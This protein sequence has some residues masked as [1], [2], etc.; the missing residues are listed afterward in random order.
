MDG[1]TENLESQ[2]EGDAQPEAPDSA[3]E[4]PVSTDHGRKTCY[5]LFID[6][7]GFSTRT[8]DEKEFVVDK[9]RKTVQA[10]N[11]YKTYQPQG[12]LISKDTGDGMLLAFLEDPLAPIECAVDVA[13][14]LRDDPRFAMRLGINS[15]LATVRENIQGQND[16]TGGAV[17]HAARVMDCGDSGHILLSGS[18]A[19]DAHQTEN[20]RPYVVKLGDA[21]VKHGEKLPIFNLC[22]EKWGNPACPKKLFQPE[23]HRMGVM[24]GVLAP[25]IAAL[26]WI[27]T[28]GVD[29]DFQ[30]FAPSWLFIAVGLALAIAMFVLVKQAYRGLA[31]VARLG[32]AAVPFAVLAALTGGV[33]L[34]PCKLNPTDSVCVEMAHVMELSYRV[35]IWALGREEKNPP[36]FDPKI[37][38][39]LFYPSG[40]GIALHVESPQE[41]YLYIL[42][43]APPVAGQ[44]PDFGGIFPVPD[45]RNGRANLAAGDSINVGDLTFDDQQGDE[46]LFLVWSA[47]QIDLLENLQTDEDGRLTDE[48]PIMEIEAFLLE[49][50]ER[51]AEPVIDGDAVKLSRQDQLFVHLLE[52]STI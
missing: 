22:S 35:E 40:S 26:P 51:R 20:F 38:S 31:G 10:T 21:T 15:G 12:K 32:K 34:D 29:I 42:N 5:V 11:A 39:N 3:A 19:G 46:R 27:R 28:G 8:L 33:G 4:A 2:G 45:V 6:V 1:D 24:A 23:K 16:I 43:E 48:A 44:P 17:D 36:V 18:V 37:S 50:I 13:G 9:L 30:S 47:K 52:F 49:N 41:G 7:V 25:I 14:T